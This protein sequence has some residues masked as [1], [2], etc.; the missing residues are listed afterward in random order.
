MKIALQYV[1]DIHGRTQ[2]VQLPVTEWEK[3]LNKLKKYEQTLKIKS[4]LQEAFEE[5]KTLQRSK[6]R[7]Q[8]LN[9]FLNEL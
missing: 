9:D 6:S 8:T 1:N 2:A 3:V 7:K 4:D 5:V